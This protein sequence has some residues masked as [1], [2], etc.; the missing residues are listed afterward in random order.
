MSFFDE[1][2]AHAEALSTPFLAEIRAFIN[3][4]EGK[5]ESVEAFPASAPVETAPVV[6]DTP[7]VIAPPTVAPVEAPAETP[8]E[9]PAESTISPE[10]NVA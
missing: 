5:Y 2:R 1:L 3:H 6:D 10:S 4:I 7:V 9:V 8:A